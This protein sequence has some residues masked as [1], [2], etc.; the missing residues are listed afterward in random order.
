MCVYIRICLSVHVFVFHV[1]RV[2][3][4]CIVYV[5]VACACECLGVFGSGY[6]ACVL[7]CKKHL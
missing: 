5:F 7:F 2:A 3:C 6:Y 4:V 1:L